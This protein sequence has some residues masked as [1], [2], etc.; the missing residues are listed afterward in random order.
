M[1][2]NFH[3]IKLK[4]L[5]QDLAHFGLYEPS[6]GSPACFQFHCFQF[7]KGYFSLTASLLPSKTVVVSDIQNVFDSLASLGL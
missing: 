5:F 1:E 2:G 4:M 7:S 6:L 3:T